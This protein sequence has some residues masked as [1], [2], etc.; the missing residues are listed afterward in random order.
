MAEHRTSIDIEAPPHRVFDFLVTDTGITSWMGQWASLD[1]VPGGRFAVDIAGY[2]ARGMFLEVDPPRRVTVSW[3]FAGNET[4]PPGSSTVSFELTPISG[5][6]R[7]EVVHT[8]LPEGDVPGH[9]AGWAHFLP[10]LTRAVAGEQLPPDTWRPAPRASTTEG[11]ALPI[12]HD[13]LSTVEAYHRAWTSGDVERALTFVSD[14]VRC[15][16]PDENVTTKND[17]HD[18]LARFVPMLTG[19]PQHS[20]MTEGDR[21][22][23]WYF[24]QTAVTSTTL[25]SELFTVRGGQIVEIRLAFDRLGYLPQQQQPS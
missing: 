23:L 17:W 12:D 16:A 8:D 18:Y 22:A 2:C 5:G 7:V 15:F 13:A 1:P 21:V 4:L 14:D 20:R 3:G 24:P 25:A 6:T 9:A 10:R 11:V 19:A